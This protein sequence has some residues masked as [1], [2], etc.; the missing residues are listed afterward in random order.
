MLMI[1]IMNVIQVGFLIRI[2]MVD[3]IRTRML[4]FDPIWIQ[5]LMFDPIGHEC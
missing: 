2:L 5:M 3:P 1:D 4:M